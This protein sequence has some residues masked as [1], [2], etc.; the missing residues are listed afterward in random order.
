MED[1]KIEKSNIYKCIQKLKIYEYND[2]INISYITYAFLAKGVFDEHSYHHLFKI[3]L[4]KEE[5]DELEQKL[6]LYNI[7]FF[8]SSLYDYCQSIL[9]DKT[10]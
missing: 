3:P 10:I 6:L 2:E 7:M 5:I 9:K 8:N 4:N 1:Q